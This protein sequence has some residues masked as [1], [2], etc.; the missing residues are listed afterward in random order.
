LSYSLFLP[1]SVFGLVHEELVPV[2][3]S[4]TITSK[5]KSK[6]SIAPEQ[7]GVAKEESFSLQTRGNIP[8][9]LDYAQTYG[10]GASGRLLLQAAPSGSTTDVS[11]V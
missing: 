8:L 7:G 3:S 9:D 11:V 1:S 2:S 10:M 6:R 4:L 5:R